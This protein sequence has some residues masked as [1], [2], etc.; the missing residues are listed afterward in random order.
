MQ[1]RDNSDAGRGGRPSEKRR[2]RAHATQTALAGMG[3]VTT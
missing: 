1:L 2:R 3:G